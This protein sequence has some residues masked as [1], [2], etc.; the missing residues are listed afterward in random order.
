MKR[1]IDRITQAARSLT[2]KD[3]VLIA[4]DGRCAS[5]KTTLAQALADRLGGTAFHMDDF[6]LRPEQRTEARLDTPGG[7]VDYERFYDEILRPL[8]EGEK[9]VALNAYDCASRSLMP[10]VTVKPEGVIIIEGAYSC[11]PFLREYYDLRVFLTVTPEEQMKRIISR[12]GAD[13]AEVF[14]KKWIPLEEKYFSECR[15]EESCDLSFDNSD[16]DIVT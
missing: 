6:F 12:N 5:G 7:N 8:S 14:R 16:T 15:T 1:I 11:H 13:Q 9:T 4:V 3:R 2:A 10:T